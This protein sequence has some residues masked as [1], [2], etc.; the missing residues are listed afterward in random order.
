M[1]ACLFVSNM[2]HGIPTRH[3]VLPGC[4]LTLVAMVT[5]IAS[6][7]IFCLPLL[8]CQ[9]LPGGSRSACYTHKHTYTKMGIMFKLKSIIYH[10]QDPINT[11]WIM[12]DTGTGKTSFHSSEA[13]LIFHLPDWIQTKA[14]HCMYDFLYHPRISKTRGHQVLFVS[15]FC[16]C[17]PFFTNS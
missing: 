9:H 11:L 4:V 14:Q 10:H 3:G 15:W 5:G 17:V 7:L 2:Q 13:R 1:S 16:G 6:R 12:C 8:Q